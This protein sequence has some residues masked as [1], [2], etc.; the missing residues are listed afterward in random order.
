MP[1]TLKRVVYDGYAEEYVREFSNGTKLVLKRGMV[2][3]VPEDIHAILMDGKKTAH[4]VNVIGIE[5]NH[6]RKLKDRLLREG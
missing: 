4:I 5:D 3:T 1:K 2:T 6:M